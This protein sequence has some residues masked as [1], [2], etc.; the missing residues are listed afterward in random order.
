MTD[1]LHERSPIYHEDVPM[2]VTLL[3]ADSVRD[4]PDEVRRGMRKQASEMTPRPAYYTRHFATSPTDYLFAIEA[5]RN[6]S[7]DPD[8]TRMERCPFEDAE[9]WSVVYRTAYDG[10]FELIDDYA[11]YSEAFAAVS[12]CAALLRIAKRL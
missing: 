9:H 6:E 3:H 11:S 7:S 8:E 10:D 1:P 12:A 2:H 4:L 5:Q